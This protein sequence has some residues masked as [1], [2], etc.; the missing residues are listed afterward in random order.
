MTNK[1]W[2][3]LTH[4][5][6]QGFSYQSTGQ[7]FC[8]NHSAET[9]S[10]STGILAR[11]KEKELYNMSSLVNLRKIALSLAIFAVITMASATWARADTVTLNLN[12]G[13]TL[14]NQLYG[15]VTLTL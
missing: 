7:S 6:P 15:T 13:S 1:N 8:D 2:S 9:I 3:G 4:A 10:L 11:N 14:P 12:T 5:Y